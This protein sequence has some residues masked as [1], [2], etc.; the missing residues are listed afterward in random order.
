MR[1]LLIHASTIALCCSLLNTASANMQPCGE[2]EFRNNTVSISQSL[3]LTMPLSEQTRACLRALADELTERPYVQSLTI[4]VRMPDDDRRTGQAMQLAETLRAEMVAKGVAKRRISAVA[5]SVGHGQRTG[6]SFAYSERRRGRP[7]AK[8]RTL[9]GAVTVGRHD[10]DMAT[11]AA[12][13]KLH[14][15]DRVATS[16]HGVALI[17]IADGSQM[18]MWPDTEV[19][20]GSISLN[21][22]YQR[23]VQIGVMRGEIETKVSKAGD[24]A[25]FELITGAAVAGVR[26]TSFRLVADGTRGT[27]LETLTGEVQLS[28]QGGAQS[29][30]AGYGSR[31]AAGQAPEQARAL[32]PAPTGMTPLRGSISAGSTLS[33]SAVTGAV[34]YRVDIAADVHFTR[35]SQRVTSTA[36][37]LALP[38]LAVGRWYWRVMAIDRD[39]FVGMPSKI[40]AFTIAQ[41]INA[42]SA[43]LRRTF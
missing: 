1:I 33:W 15:H 32:L 19:R 36:N 25:S 30:P 37:S 2:L 12:G 7:V 28:N 35:D 39:G 22:Q 17:E 4:I 42:V 9:V 20:F 8:L 24:G 5:P 43:A 38:S 31:A 34:G 14:A 21:A 13:S 6:I 26:G 29:V 11:A 27:R 40:Y 41:S 3:P 18:F 10:S 23:S 16:N